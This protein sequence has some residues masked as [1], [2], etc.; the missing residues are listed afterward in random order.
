MNMNLEFAKLFEFV[1]IR[2]VS[3]A[4][5]ETVGS[6]MNNKTGKGRYLQPENLSKEVCKTFT[7]CI[8]IFQKVNFYM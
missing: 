5:C 3:E 7:N 8:F 4:F 1:Q 6:V 2:S